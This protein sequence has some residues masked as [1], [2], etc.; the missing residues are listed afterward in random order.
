VGLKVLL[1]LAAGLFV[2][3]VAWFSVGAGLIAAA[4]VC[5][6]IAVLFYMDFPVRGES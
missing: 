6:A 2:A 5:V 3:G 1:A 4:V